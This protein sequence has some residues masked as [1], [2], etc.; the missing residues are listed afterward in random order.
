MFDNVVISFNDAAM[1]VVLLGSLLEADELPTGERR[2]AAKV[3]ADLSAALAVACE[4]GIH[5]A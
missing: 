5:S 1:A 3:C 2:M 4:V